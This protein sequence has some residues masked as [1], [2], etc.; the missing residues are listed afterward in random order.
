[1]SDC[2]DEPRQGVVRGGFDFAEVFA[3]LGRHPVHA[4][5]GVD[6]F[7]GG[8]GHDGAV[9]EPGQRP[10]AQRVAHFEGALAQRDVVRLGAGEVLERRAIGF[11]RKQAHVDLQAVG[12]ME[13]DLVLAF[14]DDVVNAGIG[15][16]VIDRGAGVLGRAGR[17]GDQQV[18]VAGGF[19]A[20]AERAGRCD[21]FN[22][23]K[24]EQIGGDSPGGFFGLVDAVAAG[25]AAIIF[26]AFAQLFDLLF[27]HAG[28]TAETAGFD[29]FGELVDAGDLR[30]V[31]EQGN[32]FGTHAGEL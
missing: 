14:G 24:C 18:E 15:G 23:R 8:R 31:P 21:F 26:D 3:H 2:C 4:Q 25:A 16:D 17:A 11:R 27:A 6:L 19:A 12:E 7:F 5:R 22:S 9:V 29:G 32:G 1:M 20:A 10:L 28:K 30:G 13:A